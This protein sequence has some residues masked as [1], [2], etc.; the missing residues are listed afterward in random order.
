MDGNELPKIQFC[1]DTRFFVEVIN[2]LLFVG[3]ELGLFGE[4]V[5]PVMESRLVRVEDASLLA[6]GKESKKLVPGCSFTK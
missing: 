3:L 5:A 6:E 4:D 2:V 1:E